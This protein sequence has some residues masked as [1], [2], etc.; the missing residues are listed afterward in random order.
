MGFEDHG[1]R[2]T[3]NR[4]RAI[5]AMSP[6]RQPQV[7]STAVDGIAIGRASVWAG[8]PDPPQRAPEPPNE[9][10]R[11]LVRAHPAGDPR[12]ST[13][14]VR[15]LP[16]AEAELFVPEVAILAELGPLLLAAGGRGS[17][18]PEEAV[19][20]ATSQVSTDLL[21]D[22]RARLLDGLGFVSDSRSVESLLEGRDGDRVLVTESLTPSVV[23]LASGPGRGDRR[24]VGRRAAPSSGEVHFARR[25]SSPAAGAFPSPSYPRTPCPRSRTTT[26]WS[27]TRPAASPRCG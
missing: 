21:L 18:A 20:E 5:P 15:R 12:A 8:N 26:P 23:A 11:R 1:L 17:N 7:G 27:S 19:N 4:Q 25:R 14:L 22:A 10:R 16:P 3:E 2:G 9:E 6:E 13:D 24:R